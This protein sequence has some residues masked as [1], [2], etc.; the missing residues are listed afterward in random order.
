MDRF[1]WLNNIILERKPDIILEIGDFADLSTL[2]VY[3][4]GT[5]KAW[6]KSY[7]DQVAAAKEASRLAFG[8]I[9]KY[10][11]TIGKRK[12]ELYEPRI[13]R[14]GGNHE[15]GRMDAF[16]NKNPEFRGHISMEDLG[17]TDHNCEYHPFLKP[18]LFQGLTASHFFYSKSQRYPAPSAK[19]ILALNMCSSLSGHSHSFDYAH[20]YNIHGRRITSVIGGCYLDTK[21]TSNAPDPNSQMSYAGPVKRWWNGL[22]YLHDVNEFGEF[23]LEQISIQKVKRNY[24]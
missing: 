2:G 6:G 13:I 12:K 22:N 18:V 14:C 19:A 8:G 16:L 5:E 11:S 15:E 20:T 17:Y 9:A 10:N 4:K 1:S 21:E 3:D 23:D 7:K 24:G